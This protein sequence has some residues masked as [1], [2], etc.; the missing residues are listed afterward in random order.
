MEVKLTSFLENPI[1]RQRENSHEGG[2]GMKFTVN[3]TVKKGNSIYG[4]G[5][6]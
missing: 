6:G 5:K 3:G 2:K 1:V 4:Q